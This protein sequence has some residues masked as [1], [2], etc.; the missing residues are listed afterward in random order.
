M[1]IPEFFKSPKTSPR[2]RMISYLTALR[3]NC[4]QL[5]TFITAQS[6]LS[7][8]LPIHKVSV[9][10]EMYQNLEEK[11]N[12]IM[13]QEIDELTDVANLY[14]T[15]MRMVRDLCTSTWAQ[16][17]VHKM[18][19]G[20]LVL[21]LHV[22]LI[23]VSITGMPTS[24]SL[25]SIVTMRMN[26]I[27]VVSLVIGLLHAF[28]LFSSSFVVN[29][30]SMVTFFIQSFILF[31]LMVKVTENLSFTQCLSFSG[32]IS[33]LY[34]TA[35]P[36]IKIMICIRLTSFFHT[37]RDQQDHCLIPKLLQRSD[38]S[39]YSSDYHEVL[40]YIARFVVPYLTFVFV[41]FY[42]TFFI[43]TVFRQQYEQFLLTKYVH[44]LIKCSYIFG[45]FGIYL[46]EMISVWLF[47]IYLVGTLFAVILAV[48]KPFTSYC[49]KRIDTNSNLTL[50]PYSLLL[51]T[52][53]IPI[54][55]IVKSTNEILFIPLSL[56][57][58]QFVLTVKVVYK[59]P[60]SELL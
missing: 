47:W 24:K 28:A 10:Q 41:L 36:F 18:L 54:C 60:Q 7:N 19:A 3:T 20:I 9:L 38:V 52:L 21:V 40:L 37:C 43:K 15:Y 59:M 2:S 31:L 26:L 1:I 17:D 42:C 51:L 58:I 35:K 46:P 14:M 11:Y 49:S 23:L 29:E 30:G 44:W 56:S 39:L 4:Q 25:Y 33:Q 50:A 16:F 45:F 27:D 8:D 13:N 32:I 5:N 53:W 55:L 48:F 6:R 12:G 22:L 57:I 34:T